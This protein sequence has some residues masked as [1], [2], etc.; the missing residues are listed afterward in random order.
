MLGVLV[1][2]GQ[3]RAGEAANS[4]AKPLTAAVI[5]DV[6]YGDDQEAAFGT[7]IDA[8][9]A[10]PKVRDVVHVGDI[11]SG[12]TVCSDSRCASVAAAFATFE[13]PLI[14]TPGDNE[15]TD[16]HRINNG[17]FDPL[18]RLDALRSVFFAEPGEP[19]GRHPKQLAAQ[20][21]FPENVLWT[22]SR[23][24]FAT[25]H[26]IGSNNGLSPW[27]GTGHTTPTPSKPRRSTPGR[28][29]R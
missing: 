6:P 4:S 8:V 2:P 15:W 5:G 1:V 19:V 20:Q 17:Q 12:S 3:V 10:D 23:V 18:E 26:V 14:Y 9:N 13:D 24:T 22:G 16:R 11:K 28:T 29:P 25:V 27:T 7:L 21:G